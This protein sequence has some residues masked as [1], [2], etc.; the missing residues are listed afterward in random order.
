LLLFIETGR[1]VGN[2]YEGIKS[3]FMCIASTVEGKFNLFKKKTK[4]L[5]NIHPNNNNSTLSE[6]RAK[7]CY[8]TSIDN[9]N[10]IF[11]IT[12]GNNSEMGE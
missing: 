4:S 2:N 8:S 3:M 12:L 10:D 7:A 5:T 11:K 6:A 9:H 1:K